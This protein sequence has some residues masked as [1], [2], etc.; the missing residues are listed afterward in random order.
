MICNNVLEAIGNT[1]LIR[2]NRMVDPDSAQVLVKFEGLNVGGSIKT[3]TAY[4]MIKEAEEQG[5]IHKDTII[6]ELYQ[7]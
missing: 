6:V 5:L 2:L 4:N 1:P 3:R 7:W